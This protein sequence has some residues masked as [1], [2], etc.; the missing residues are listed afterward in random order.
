MPQRSNIGPFL[1]VLYTQALETI[2]TQECEHN[3]THSGDLFDSDCSICGIVVSFADD[4]SII[5]RMRRGECL[6]I[7]IELDSTLTN[8]KIFPQSNGLKLNTE[9]I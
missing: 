9:K 2:M 1:F 6:Q 3:V 7:S 8:L 4:A 5:I